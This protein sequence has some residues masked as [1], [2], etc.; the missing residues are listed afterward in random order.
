[1]LAYAGRLWAQFLFLHKKVWIH[2]SLLCECFNSL[3]NIFSGVQVGL[4]VPLADSVL[5]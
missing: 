2:S 5:L 1:M 3:I 4:L